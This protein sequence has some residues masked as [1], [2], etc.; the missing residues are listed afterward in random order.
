MTVHPSSVGRFGRPT[1]RPTATAAA[2]A[3]GPVDSKFAYLCFRSPFEIRNPDA[4]VQLEL[5][6]KSEY[7]IIPNQFLGSNRSSIEATHASVSWI[8]MFGILS[9]KFDS[10]PHYQVP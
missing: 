10:L 1:V 2:A 8:L 9:Q 7:R 3:V 5:R 6:A 4:K